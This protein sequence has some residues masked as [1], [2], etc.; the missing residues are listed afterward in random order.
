MR[1]TGGQL[2]GR[3]LAS[4]AGMAV[5]P[6]SDRVREALFS[7][8]G[9]VADLD[10]LDVC[11]GAGTLGLEALSRGAATATFIEK[12]P[13]ARAAIER[14]LRELGLGRQGALLR[15]G[16][17]GAL[18]KLGAE[19]RRFHL[20]FIDPPYG[21]GILQ[22]C[23]EAVADQGLLSAGGV[24]VAEHDVADPLPGTWGGGALRLEEAR[25]YGRTILS[26]YGAGP[27]AGAS[28]VGQADEDTGGAG[29][30]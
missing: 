11:A 22:G 15:G 24:L 6:T 29:G 25:R 28:V 30:C 19:R 1:L 26:L 4:P 8:L 20:I 17:P 7:I 21:A 10:V 18:V 9:D 5:R 27:G 12:A 23:L 3:R 16:A 13:A 14:N 2:R